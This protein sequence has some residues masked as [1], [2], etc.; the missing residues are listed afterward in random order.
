MLI[1]Q[2][3]IDPRDNKK[4]THLN[5]AQSY[6]SCILATI[7]SLFGLFIAIGFFYYGIKIFKVFRMSRTFKTK[8]YQARKIVFVCMG[9]TACFVARAVLDLVTVYYTLKEMNELSSNI[10]WSG[11]EI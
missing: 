3:R 1:F 9:C 8:K 10:Q 4:Q 7:L 6:V 2:T 5:D 11:K